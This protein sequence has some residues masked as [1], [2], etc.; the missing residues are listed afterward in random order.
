MPYSTYPYGT[1]ILKI[2]LFYNFTIIYLTFVKQF[3]V[4]NN[5]QDTQKVMYVTIHK[6]LKG[7]ENIYELFVAF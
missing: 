3:E 7:L 4:F 2:I 1:D 6:N 5:F